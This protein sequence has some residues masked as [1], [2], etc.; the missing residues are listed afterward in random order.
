[1]F[2]TANRLLRVATSSPARSDARGDGGLASLALAGAVLAEI[3][4]CGIIIARVAYTEIDWV[5]Y[6]QEVKGFLDGER[7]Y[8]NLRGDTGPLVYPAG[9]VYAYSL[10]YWVTD[11]GEDIFTA[12][13]IF[14]GVYV[15]LMVM[16]LS[17]YRRAGSGAMPLWSILLVCT[18][19]RVHSIFVLRLFNDGVAM[20][21]L[22]GAVYLFLL[23]RWRLGCVSYSLAVGVKMN[24]L[25]FAPGLLLL[26]VQANGIGGAAVCLSICAGV[27][28]LLGAPFLLQHPVAYLSRSFELGRVF[29]FEWTVNF[30]F[31]TEE[32]FVS[33][34]LSVA[35]LI[36]TLVALALFA[37][38]W[39]RSAREVEAFSASDLRAGDGG[40]GA[41]GGAVNAA[42]H[43]E[44]VVKTLFVS[45][46]IGI[47][48]CRSLHYQFYSWYYHTLPFLLWQTGLPVALRLVVL[49]GVEVG[50]NVFPATALS[51]GVLQVC[52]VAILAGLWVSPVV[53]KRKAATPA[54][55]KRQ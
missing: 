9:F 29:K 18:S 48:F 11:R 52:H 53:V 51:S 55:A 28:L 38:K 42:L 16:V 21:L 46:F 1:M 25:L 12:Q 32:A 7:N 24:I 23:N 2:G 10:L 4:L 20:W 34:R 19:R 3:A 31:L 35:L 17:I 6:M 14:M 36:L 43:P 41:T 45:N 40:G 13:Y 27:Q 15:S 49:C 54:A 22:Y 26:L 44:Y 37:S 47:V 5:A 30:K 50:F 8:L 33:P 39:L